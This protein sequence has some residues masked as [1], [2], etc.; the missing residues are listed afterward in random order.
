MYY[1]LD[2]SYST[3]DFNI[4][5]YNTFK[6]INKMYCD[7]HMVKLIGTDDHHNTFY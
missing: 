2:E 3:L 5:T 1:I 7:D 6:L 4:Q